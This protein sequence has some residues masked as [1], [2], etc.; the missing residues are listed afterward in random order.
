MI[1]RLKVHA[2]DL[3]GCSGTIEFGETL[4]SIYNKAT[5]DGFRITDMSWKEVLR[6]QKKAKFIGK[7]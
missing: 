4:T 2:K 7:K 1:Q 3:N 5:K 6:A